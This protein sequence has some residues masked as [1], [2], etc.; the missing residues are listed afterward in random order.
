MARAI[1]M[2]TLVVWAT[3]LLLA[4][5]IANAQ[6]V[7]GD[8]VGASGVYAA[9]IEVKGQGESE[10]NAAFARGL[11]QVLGKLSGDR[12]AASQPGVGQELRKA[13][14]YV[15]GYDYRQDEGISA[16]GAP[17]FG[18]TLVIR[19][20]EEKVDAMVAMLGVPVWPQPRPKPVLWLAIDDGGGPRLVGLSQANAARAA[21]DRAITRGYR[22][23]LPGGSAAEQAVVGAIWRG[24]TA[25]VARASRR[26]D[27]PMQLVGKLYRSQDGWTADW[28]FIDNGRVLSTWSETGADARGLMAGGADG[29]ADAL[30]KRY[31]K[32][33][34]AGP[35]GKYAVMFTGIN[36][37]DDFMRLSGYLQGLAVVRGI[38]PLRAT[39]QGV[40]FELELRSGLPGLKRAIDG[41]NVL[42]G[43]NVS[44]TPDG[45]SGVE[46]GRPVYRLR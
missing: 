9:E 37:S 8:R 34:P 33:A 2:A 30:T 24:D 1:R 3:A 45:V 27:P 12:R 29:A 23:G 17:S 42:D 38:T 11:A 26:Y 18:T 4:S 43:T 7:E 28:T 25:A 6:R 39:P 16:S 15:T 44:S 20:D 36:S 31:A 14:E 32:R 41:G 40:V 21:L 13:R 22:L 5:T 35:S 46:S 19:Y 10:R